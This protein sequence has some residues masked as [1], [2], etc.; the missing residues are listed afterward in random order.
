MVVITFL[1]Q[2]P[3]K[4]LEYEFSLLFKYTVNI[5]CNYVICVIME[6]FEGLNGTFYN[7][8]IKVI[9]AI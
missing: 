3:F 2:Y 1:T 7:M 6:K 4:C 9:I 8:L 5:M